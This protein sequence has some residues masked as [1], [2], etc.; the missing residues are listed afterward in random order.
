[1]SLAILQVGENSSEVQT[2]KFQSYIEFVQ[3][4][5]NAELGFVEVEVLEHVHDET[6]QF[7]VFHSVFIGVVLQL[8]KAFLQVLIFLQ[9]SIF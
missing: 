8:G 2:K 1:L 4:L 5:E 7:S 3:E 6:L 9:K